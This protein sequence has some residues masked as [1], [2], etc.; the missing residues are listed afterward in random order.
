MASD[1]LALVKDLDG[2]PGDLGIQTLTHQRGRNRIPVIMDVNH[3]VDG[4][5][6]Q[7]DV[8][9]A[10]ILLSW[11]WL[12]QVFF[13]LLKPLSATDLV[14]LH[15]LLIE[16]IDKDG[17][18]R[19]ERLQRIK[20]AVTQCAQNLAL[21]KPNGAFDRGLVLGPTNARRIG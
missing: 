19:I 20:N 5:R 11:Q 6:R 7:F 12:Q 17:D 10:L 8:F 1:N 9:T 14:T 3:I 16:L 15:D 4:H 21:R 13:V 18:G 2:V